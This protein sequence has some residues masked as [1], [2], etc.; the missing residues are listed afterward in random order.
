MSKP[1]PE[2]ELRM[3]VLCCPFGHGESLT[4]TRS[5]QRSG[6]GNSGRVGTR[7]LKCRTCGEP[8]KL[9]LQYEPAHFRKLE[10][11]PGDRG[12]VPA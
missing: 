6:D 11:A 2:F 5:E 4:V 7:W 10:V 12:R 3:P 9:A 8:F 1:L